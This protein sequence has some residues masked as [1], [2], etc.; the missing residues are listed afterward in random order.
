M[1]KSLNSKPDD[2][3]TKFISINGKPIMAR[4]SETYTQ[5]LRDESIKSNV[6]QPSQHDDG[7]PLMPMRQVQFGTKRGDVV[8]EK[9]V[10]ET[11]PP[12][13]DGQRLTSDT[14]EDP[15]VCAMKRT[16]AT[17]SSSQKKSFLNVVTEETKNPTNPKVNFRSLVNSE[18]VE[19]FDC[20][21]PVE[22]VIAAQNKFA[23]SCWKKVKV[24]KVPV[25][26]YSEDGLSVIATQIG[27]PIMFDAFTSAMCAE[28]WGRLGFARALIEVTV[29][30]E[31]KH[32]VTMVVPVVDEEGHAME[33]ME[34]EYDWKPSRCSECLVFG[35]ANEQCPK[36][37]K[38]V[39]KE[40]ATAQ[41]DGFTTVQNRKKKGKKA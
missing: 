8:H 19:N 17:P 1:L 38:E 5:P 28:P 3:A 34:I 37:V 40:D 10:N 20:V 6:E 13:D 12:K 2:L 31:L 30:K 16:E 24:H 33:K 4:R 18:Q 7:N 36:R 22:H 25:V 21:I 32:E 9:P 11:Q 23:N 15:N 29:E 26:A 14:W 41:S 35:H 39:P 27:K